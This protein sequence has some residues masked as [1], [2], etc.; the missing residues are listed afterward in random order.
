M[1]DEDRSKADLLRELQELRERLRQSQLTSLAVESEL[2][3]ARKAARDRLVEIDAIYENTGFGLCVLD[4]EMRYVRI[5]GELAAMNGVS[6]ADHIGK[7][8]R[9]VVP[10]I[11]DE[12]EP[13]F[14]KVTETGEPVSGVEHYGETD[15][16]PGVM[17]HSVS[18]WLP[19]KSPNDETTGVVVVVEEVTARKQ[20]QKA[21]RDSES[22]SAKVLDASLNGVYVYDMKKGANV[23][24]NEQYT[25]LTGYTL[26]DINAMTADQF[27]ALFHAD[28]C[29]RIAAL[30]EKIRCAKDGEVLE[31][32]YRARSADGRWIWYLSWDSVFQRDE[33]GNVTQLIGTFLDITEQRR[34]YDQV[35][36]SEQKYRSLAENSNDIPYSLDHYGRITYVGPQVARYGFVPEDLLFGSFQQIV[37]PA[38]R[39]AVTAD[40]QRALAANEELPTEFRIRASDGSVRW[41]EDCGMIQHDVDGKAIGISGVLRDITVRK[42]LEKALAELAEQERCR[43][44]RELHDGLGQEITAIGMMLSTFSVSL[45]DH[46]PHA[47][48]A[49]KLVRTIESI[50][51]QLRAMVNGLFPVA[52]DASGLGVALENLADETTETYGIECVF[53]CEQSVL[54]ENNFVATQLILIAREAVH[55]AAKHAKPTRI[56]IQLE[57]HDGIRLAVRDDGTGIAVN[58]E[59]AAGMGVRIM[60][61][62][63]SLIGAHLKFDSPPSGGTLVTCL[64]QATD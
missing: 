5:N 58:L 2:A 30:L 42:K 19:L 47:E 12:V 31:I 25:R 36:Q 22:F 57:D 61:H 1:N 56:V 49:A 26:E 29:P 38:D 27:S 20:E 4:K 59:E 9:E 39:E 55:N 44:S 52:V 24:I 45:G 40:F 46:S 8:V 41:L 23:Y 16:R 64:L 54:V 60:R 35:L 63:C 14:R 53:E 48:L 28:D 32:E 17:R 51:T 6:P 13:V 15:K 18:H 21:L 34:L 33:A 50:K 10:H 43:F 3:E 62:R 37:L 11:Y 7:T